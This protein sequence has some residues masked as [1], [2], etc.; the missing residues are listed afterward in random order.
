MRDDQALETI[1]STLCTKQKRANGQSNH[2][3][4]VAD[5]LQNLELP[6]VPHSSRQSPSSAALGHVSSPTI[7]PSIQHP[8]Y[9]PVS[10]QWHILSSFRQMEVY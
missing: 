10:S 1:N 4:V 9:L 7:G 8:P 2:N 5:R 6:T 3:D